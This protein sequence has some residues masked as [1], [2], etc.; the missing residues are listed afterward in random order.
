MAKGRGEDIPST[1][2]YGVLYED[3]VIGVSNLQGVRRE[4]DR[5]RGKER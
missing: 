1:A 3:K 2:R 5:I 4:E